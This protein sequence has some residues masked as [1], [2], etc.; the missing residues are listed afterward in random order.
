MITQ[1]FFDWADKVGARSHSDLVLKA[2]EEVEKRVLE[3]YKRTPA[4]I[5]P[6]RIGV[7]FLNLKKEW[8]GK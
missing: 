7:H 6:P 4:K 5:H 8:F 1:A 2:F 3:N